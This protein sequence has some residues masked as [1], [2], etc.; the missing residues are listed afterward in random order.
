MSERYEPPSDFLKALIAGE[1]PLTG[2]SFADA[3]LRRLIEM[4]RDDDLANRDWATMLLA[5]HEID[6]P[7]VKDA[8]LIA[9]ADEDN[10][11]KAE[12]LLG[13]AQRD[14]VLALPLVKAALLCDDACVPLFAAAEM[15]A[16]PSLVPFLSAW[17]E[18]SGDKFLDRC[19]FDALTACQRGKRIAGAP[20][21]LKTP[22]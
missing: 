21:N 9:A 8:L 10:V 3:N 4:M 11:V 16:D 19:A 17:A 2:D 6:T 13:L 22:S 12:A 15:I 20:D 7:E 14:K 1:V 5:Q 18:P